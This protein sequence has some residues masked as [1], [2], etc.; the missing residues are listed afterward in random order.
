ML[1][2]NYS[3]HSA[4]FSEDCHVVWWHVCGFPANSTSVAVVPPPIGSFSGRTVKGFSVITRKKG[5]KGGE[6]SR[7]TPPVFWIVVTSDVTPSVSRRGGKEGGAAAR[8]IAESPGAL[9]P[10]F[11]LSFVERRPAEWFLPEPW[12]D[13]WKSWAPF[14]GP[15][16]PSPETPRCW[17]RQPPTARLKET[18]SGGWLDGGILSIFTLTLAA[19]SFR[20]MRFS[21]SYRL[22]GKRLNEPA[23]GSM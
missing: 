17:R 6:R 14:R 12:L 2:S 16:P 10:L 18:V 13:I 11:A 7:Q 19:V 4:Y 22:A 20:E 1:P 5:A 21:F 15:P 9:G 3:V 8:Y 23:P